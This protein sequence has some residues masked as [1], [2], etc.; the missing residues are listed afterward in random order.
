MVPFQI[1]TP[2][3]TNNS[4][5][6][7]LYVA[8]SHRFT[9]TKLPSDL[10]SVFFLVPC[11]SLYKE[12]YWSHYWSLVNKFADGSMAKLVREMS[13]S[14]WLI[15]IFLIAHAFSSRLRSDDFLFFLLFLSLVLLSWFMMLTCKWFGWNRASMFQNLATGMMIMYLY[16]L[17]WKC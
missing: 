17:L 3:N 15:L 7:F 6:V 2:L 4:K 9:Y 5:G 14:L 13:L 8:S 11:L 1:K 12:T 16:N 10:S